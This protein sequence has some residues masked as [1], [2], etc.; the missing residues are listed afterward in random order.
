MIGSDESPR[1]RE[2]CFISGRGIALLAFDADD[3][4]AGQANRRA[5]DHDHLVALLYRIMLG[6]HKARMNNRLDAARFREA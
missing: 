4:V 1:P 6:V 3:V 2:H 5:H